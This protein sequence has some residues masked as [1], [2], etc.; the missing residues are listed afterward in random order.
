MMLEANTK[1][2]EESSLFPSILFT[3]TPTLAA[4]L[5]KGTKSFWLTQRDRTWTLEMYPGKELA[6]SE[7]KDPEEEWLQHLFQPQKSRWF[8]GLVH[9]ILPIFFKH[10]RPNICKT[11]KRSPGIP[12]WF[13]VVS[14]NRTRAPILAWLKFTSEVG[15]SAEA[16]SNFK[17][18]LMA[19][20]QKLVSRVYAGARGTKRSSRPKDLPPPP[21]QIKP[22]PTNQPQRLPL[23]IKAEISYEVKYFR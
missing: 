3:S 13:L 7:I 19:L 18:L 10:W 9:L 14:H 21:H 15:Q 1:L 4:H 20:G 16:L 12:E 23:E 17:Q 6:M 2:K 22:N 5:Q 11:D 8:L